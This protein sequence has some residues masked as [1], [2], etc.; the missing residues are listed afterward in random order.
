MEYLPP[1]PCGCI[2]VFQCDNRCVA[3]ENV[4]Q[5]ERLFEM[6]PA[7]CSSSLES[8]VRHGHCVDETMPSNHEVIDTH[9]AKLAS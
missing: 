1:F 7:H 6:P 4:M 5:S 3:S 9:R 2:R 8:G